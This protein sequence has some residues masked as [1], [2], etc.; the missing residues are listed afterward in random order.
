M[1]YGEFLCNS[2]GEKY[3]VTSA[4]GSSYTNTSPQS[5]INITAISVIWKANLFNRELGRCEI[6]MITEWDLPQLTTSA[7]C[8]SF[9][10]PRIKTR[11]RRI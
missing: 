8:S 6:G 4:A 3:E 10:R 11:G 5:F 1:V 7:Q 9:V 2:K